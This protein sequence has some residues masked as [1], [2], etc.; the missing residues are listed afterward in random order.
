MDP[1]HNCISLYEDLKT[2]SEKLQ[3]FKPRFKQLQ[4][5]LENYITYLLDNVSCI[6]IKVF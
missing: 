4:E 6:V 1:V 5:K 3:M 2:K